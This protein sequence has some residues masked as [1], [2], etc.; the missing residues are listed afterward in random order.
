MPAQTSKSCPLLVV[1]VFICFFL[2][3]LFDG[4]PRADQRK[5]GA[6][7]DEP[8]AIYAKNPDDPWNRIFYCLFS[9]RVTYRYSNEFPEGA[10]FN[11]PTYVPMS[12]DARDLQVSTGLF[13]RFET[14]D[15]AIDPL[16]PID[17]AYPSPYSGPRQVLNDPLYTQLVEA[18]REAQNEKTKRPALARA[19]MQS[20]LWAAFDILYAHPLE[21]LEEHR[22]ILLEMLAYFLKKIALPRVVIEALPDN[23]SLALGE[24][25]LPDLFAAS[26]GWIEVQWFPDREHDAAAGFR[27]VTRVFI[28][29]TH[30]AKN[31]QKFLNSLRAPDRQDLVAELDGVAIVTQ[32]LLID[33]QD[34][35]TPSRVT[36][37]VQLRLFAKTRD[38]RFKS[39]DMREYELSR[40]FALSQNSSGGFILE[41]ETAPAYLPAAGN[42]YGFASRLF[43]RTGVDPPL[44]V[45]LRTRCASCHGGSD[46][47][48]VMTFAMHPDPRVP[49]PN[50]KHLDP[51]SHADYVIS[52]KIAED[53]WG[54]LED[55]I[56]SLAPR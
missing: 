48:F 26:G 40:G 30:A 35:I 21:Q 55:Y 9:R 4:E 19:L 45:K 25:G 41:R 8:Q 46:L 33:D 6:E 42:D 7:A 17:P 13:E 5:D 39:T 50:V 1:L 2:G 22:R 10:P 43:T 3:A 54:S 31:T 47:T 32:L 53:D 16:Y 34:K 38:G 44:L 20:D 18:L 11:P 49:T 29:P 15:R 51:A 28:K 12:P 37:D 23:Y 14:G 56:K 36:S 24:S 52:R 27:R